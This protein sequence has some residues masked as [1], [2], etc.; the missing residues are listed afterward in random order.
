MNVIMFVIAIVTTII[1]YPMCHTYVTMTFF[2]HNMKKS[3]KDI[4]QNRFRFFFRFHI[5]DSYWIDFWV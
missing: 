1:N 5:E 2:D 3:E 4:H